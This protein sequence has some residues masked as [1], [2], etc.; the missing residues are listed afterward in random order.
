MQEGN[1]TGDAG[2]STLTRLESFIAAQ[3]GDSTP[4]PK[5]ES[6]APEAEE[7]PE[8]DDTNDDSGPQLTLAELAKYLDIEETAL[9]VDDAGKLK[10]KTKI[11]G[12]EGAA[13]LAELIKSYQVQGHADAKAREVAE[14]Q[15][16]LTEKVQQFEQFARNEAQRLNQLAQVAQ[17]ELYAEY[18]NLDWGSLA[19]NDPAQYVALQHQ[20]QMRQGRINQLIA[21]ATNY[22][23]QQQQMDQARRQQTLQSEQQRLHSLIPEWTNQQVFEAERAELLSWA[24]QNGITAEDVGALQKAEFIVALRK[25]MLLDKGKTTTEVIKKKVR[26]APKLVKPGQSVDARQQEAD[27]VRTIKDT[28]R[29]TGGREGIAAYLLATGKV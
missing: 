23:T 6:P 16:Q 24:K 4:S 1:P 13:K 2:A 12:K 8:G 27:K 22:Q 26:A 5:D 14:A 3:E 11:D 19:Q 18:A 25:A 29:K 17:Q 21:Q 15:K 10:V 28:I 20:V 9:D 7:K